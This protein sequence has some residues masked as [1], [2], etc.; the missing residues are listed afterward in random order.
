ME[1][2]SE[3]HRTLMRWGGHTLGLCVCAVLLCQ[4]CECMLYAWWHDHVH[5]ELQAQPASLVAGSSVAGGISKSLL[6]PCELLRVRQ[7]ETIVFILCIN[8]FVLAEHDDIV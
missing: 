5:A 3:N 7:R 6:V 4:H 8:R 1:C 2:P